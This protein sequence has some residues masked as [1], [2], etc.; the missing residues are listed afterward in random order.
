MVG[1][2]DFNGSG[3]A[4]VLW[5]NQSSG[6][7]ARVDHPECREHRL[8][9]YRHSRP[10]DLEVAGVGDFNGDGTADMLWQ[11]QSTGL[12]GE[13]LIQNAPKTPVGRQFGPGGSA[14]LEG[15]RRGRLQRRRYPDILW[16]NQSSGVVGTWLIQNVQNAGWT[17]LGQ[18]DPTRWQ[19]LRH[20]LAAK[21]GFGDSVMTPRRLAARGGKSCGQLRANRVCR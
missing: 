13:W 11:N 8:G 7:V 1:V 5:Q 6:L 16:Q 12:V 19:I 18:A 15:G 3:T 4:D 9:Q 14:E 21:L 2:G 17:Q 10:A 20:S